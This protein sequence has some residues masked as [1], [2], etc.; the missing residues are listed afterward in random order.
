MSCHISES[1]G[2]AQR[3]YLNF[4]ARTSCCDED[5]EEVCGSSF[6]DPSSALSSHVQQFD[7]SP[8]SSRLLQLLIIVNLLWDFIR[9]SQRNIIDQRRAAI[10]TVGAPRHDHCPAFRCNY[11]GSPWKQAGSRTK[12]T[13]RPA[14]DRR[15][16]GASSCLGLGNE[17][18][19]VEY[20][21]V[22]IRRLSSSFSTDDDSWLK[23][24]FISL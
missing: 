8:C 13:I 4:K 24:F 2:A 19:Y 14:N 18:V 17:S 9:R 22:V 10:G 15:N 20:T 12:G 23:M 16:P 3:V 1:T 6:L 21:V 7:R 5:P 11:E